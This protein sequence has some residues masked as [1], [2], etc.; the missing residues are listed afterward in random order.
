MNIELFVYP[1][2]ILH[3]SQSTN[4]AKRCRR[5]QRMTCFVDLSRQSSVSLECVESN[6]RIRQDHTERPLASCLN[7]LIHV[8]YTSIF[9][10]CILTLE[11]SQ[12]F[13]N[14]SF[15]LKN[16]SVQETPRDSEF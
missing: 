2:I 1:V 6:E 7:M 5:M 11:N 3:N 16:S 13:A 12:A 9:S 10:R 15:D 14:L 8:R 4:T